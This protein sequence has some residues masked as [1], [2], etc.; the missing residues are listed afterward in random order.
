MKFKAAVIAIHSLWSKLNS[1]HYPVHP[2]TW[3]HPIYSIINQWYQQKDIDFYFQPFE[4]CPTR[5]Q[6]QT[7]TLQNIPS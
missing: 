2:I 7:R 5:K 1:T 4:R 6:F 3:L